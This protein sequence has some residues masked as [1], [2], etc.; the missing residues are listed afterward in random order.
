MAESM[1]CSNGVIRVVQRGELACLQV[2]HPRACALIAL[3]GAQVLE[4]T[5]AGAHPVIWLSETAA[6]TRGQ[7]VRGGIPVC[8]PW[9]G[10]LRRNPVAVQACIPCEQ[11]PAHGWVR[12]L[13]WLLEQASSDDN[14]VNIRLRYPLPAGVPVDWAAQASLSLSLQIGSELVLQL[15]T[16]N[17]GAQPLTL[18]QALH[19]YF[20]A[21]HINHIRIE[22]LQ[23]VRYIDTLR[24]WQTFSDSDTL[25]I[26]QE[27]DRIY[28]DI[29]STLTIEDTG[30]QR[31]IEIHCAQSRSA[32]I[33]NPWIEKAK[34]LSHFAEDAYQRM[35]CIET[36]RVMEDCLDLA[37]GQTDVM[38]VRI[39]DSRL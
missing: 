19:T 37:P 7:S 4:Y 39:Q 13:P 31:R 27:T 38:T 8:W 33:W 2:E 1:T 23:Q 15:E 35:L 26:N 21:S 14:G 36:A 18:S 30:W 20:A 34:R 5:P 3:Q 10:D 32:V 25:R 28:L 9:F 11:P 22:P 24:D 6:F 12:N 17:L 16:T 29:P